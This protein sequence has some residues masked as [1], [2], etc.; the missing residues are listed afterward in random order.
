M[1]NV[2]KLLNNHKYRYEKKYVISLLNE[3]NFFFHLNK[4]PYLFNKEYEDRQVN[5]IYFDT[6]TMMCY[7]DNV[8]GVSNRIKVRIRWYGDTFGI[9]KNPVLEIK[10]KKNSVGSKTLF[11][12]S[13]INVDNELNIESIHT[14]FTKL[15]IP[16][17]IKEFLLSLRMT[18]MNSYSRK[19]F[20]SKDKKFRLTYDSKLNFFLVAN[21][22]N[23]YNK[24]IRPTSR[25]IFEIKYGENMSD[26][27]SIISNYF[28]FRM[29]KSSKYV[30]G[31][32]KLKL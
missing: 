15:E 1:K 18:V 31:V 25:R 12:L 11:N 10:I 14:Q 27:A 13:K 16:D 19:Y 7:W 24:V 30:F 8:S 3:N 5:N 6:P 28:P 17:E 32:D 20:I 23:S 26:M 4:H 2:I 29:T 9:V 22:S 21:Y